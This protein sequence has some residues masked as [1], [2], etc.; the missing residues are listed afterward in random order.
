MFENVDRFIKHYNR[1]EYLML[2]GSGKYN[3][4]Q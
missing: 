2:F 1:T 3:K 4:F